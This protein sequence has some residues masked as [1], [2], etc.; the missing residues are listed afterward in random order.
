VS[1][2][3]LLELNCFPVG[4][5]ALREDRGAPYSNFYGGERS[6]ITSPSRGRSGKRG[7]AAGA[8]KTR[9][10]ESRPLCGLH[11]QGDSAGETSILSLRHEREH[12]SEV[13][14]GPRIRRE[15]TA[16]TIWRLRGP[17]KARSREGSGVEDSIKSVHGD[18]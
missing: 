9:P 2:P 12:V 4:S 7:A 5:G 13:T 6:Y 11:R 16:Q 14:N 3:Q 18:V 15:P 10:T 17:A 1:T 8:R